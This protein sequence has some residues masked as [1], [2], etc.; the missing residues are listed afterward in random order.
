MNP[1]HDRLSE[2]QYTKVLKYEF[3]DP[4]GSW[5]QDGDD[6]WRWAKP[7]YRKPQA[8]WDSTE[9]FTRQKVWYAERTTEDQSDPNNLEFPDW[10]HCYWD[11]QAGRWVLLYSEPG[12]GGLSFIEFEITGVGSVSTSSTSESTSSSSEGD[13]NLCDDESIEEIGEVTAK[14]IRRPCGV[15]TVPEEEGGEVTLYDSAAGGF[16]KSR[17]AEELEGKTGF[18]VYLSNP[19][20]TPEDASISSSLSVSIE[21]EP[22]CQ[23]VIVWINWFVLTTGVKDIIFGDGKITV[24]RHNFEVWRECDL[25][26][27]VIEGTDCEEDSSSSGSS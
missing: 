11:S 25:E 4:E 3:E 5:E 22:K 9:G 18:A 27:E 14:V 21:S 19:E 6:W 17:R 16:L 23:W 20:Y 26:D 7:V 13:S 12:S 2:R 10:V 8:S 1:N 15:G 24:E